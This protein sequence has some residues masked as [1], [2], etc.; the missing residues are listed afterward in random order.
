M[1]EVEADSSTPR[2]HRQ[3]QDQGQGNL[4]QPPPP[5]RPP[6]HLAAG[7]GGPASPTSQGGG[8]LPVRISA[9]FGRGAGPSRGS[10]FALFG[11]TRFVTAR[12]RVRG[13]K[14]GGD[15]CPTE[16]SWIGE[17][18]GRPCPTPG[19]RLPPFALFGAT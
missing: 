9:Q 6:P 14:P 17:W 12:Q 5:P 18:S 4:R 15:A 16:G 10:T 1:A 11:A 7:A 13:R 2:R 3:G 8:A 19:E